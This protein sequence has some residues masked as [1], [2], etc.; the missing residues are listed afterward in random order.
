MVKSLSHISLAVYFALAFLAPCGP[1]GAAETPTTSRPSIDEA[2]RLL[3]EKRFREA[4]DMALAVLPEITGREGT[5]SPA[6]ADVMDVIDGASKEALMAVT[7]DLLAMAEHA[8]RIR[9]R[10]EEIDAAPLSKSLGILGVLLLNK[11]DFVAARSVFERLVAV[12]EKR[13]GPEAKETGW[14]INKLAQSIAR[15]GDYAAS[16]PHF[17]RALE[18]QE[19]VFGLEHPEVASTLNDFGLTTHYM[20]EYPA[21]RKLLERALAIREKVLGPEDPLTAVSAGNLAIVLKD[22]G[23]LAGAKQMYERALAIREKTLGPNHPWVAVGLVGLANVLSLA[24][25]YAEARPLYERGLAIQEKTLGAEHPDYA[26]ALENFSAFLRN[27]GDYSGA[28]RGYEQALAIL[29]KGFGPDKPQVATTL[30]SLAGVLR[31]LGDY[32]RAR[33]VN[34]RALRILE[35]TVGPDH[36]TTATALQNLASLEAATGNLAEARRLLER[37]LAIRDKAL[38]PEH[39]DVAETLDGLARLRLL[40]GDA[41]GARELLERSTAIK[42][43]ALGP[44]HP[45][46][47]RTLLQ[48][49]KVL[50][51]LGRSAEAEAQFERA[52]AI[53]NRA[54]PAE[55]PETAD[56]LSALGRLHSATGALD[57][58]GPLLERALAIRE[59]VL[60]VDHPSVADALNDLAVLRWRTGAA[61]GEVLDLALRAEGIAREQ[62]RKTAGGLSEAEA[63]RYEAIRATGLDAALTVL[64]AKNAPAEAPASVLD[65]LVRSRALVLD[66]IA[67][68]HRSIVRDADPETNALAASLEA[69]RNRLVR[70]VVAGPDPNH[71]GLYADRLRKAQAQRERAERALAGRST[72]FDRERATGS[73]GI[74]EVLAALPPGA[75]LV[76]YVVFD[77]LEDPLPATAATAARR[78]KS[79]SR[80]YLAFVRA[81]GGGATKVVPLGGAV[82]IDSLIEQW[83]REAGAR[84][85]LLTAGTREVEVLYRKIG[86]QLRKRVWDPVARHL[87][88]ARVVFVVPDGA[89]HLVSLATLPGADGRYLVET[90]RLVRY[91]SAERDLARTTPPAAGGRGLLALG[92]PDFDELSSGSSPEDVPSPS[93]QPV[94]RGATASCESFASL[95]FAPLQAA[96]QEVEEITELWIK[97]APSERERTLGL[98]GA[99]ADEAS[100][101]RLAPG[102]RILHLATHGFFA[103]DRCLSALSQRRRDPAAQALA[104]DNPL[105]LSGL[106]LAGANRRTQSGAVSGAGEDGILTADE[107][108]SIDLTSVEWA[109]LSACETGVGQVQAG[110]GVLGLRRAFQIAGA[111][112]LIMSLW[113]VEDESAREWMRGLY[114]NR[115]AGMSTAE[116]V[117]EASRGMIEARRR[118]GESTHPFYWGAFV[119]AGVEIRGIR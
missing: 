16:K 84:P 115:I 65:Q 9:E 81:P 56:A 90:G 34:E 117:R 46:V 111:A 114:R 38:G 37:A 55:H 58:A 62:F 61:G 89:L 28:R 119:A 77:R 7:P 43:K 75:A 49:G 52:L 82:A 107:I 99:E 44:E 45:F 69:A 36:P 103:Q 24:G 30:A 104:G 32:P 15:T 106:A 113:E 67:R 73:V 100:F 97:G 59:K 91:V 47:A 70:L 109:V 42:E 18:I 51:E 25:D 27:M 64:T 26:F 98:T 50:Q 83:R 78:K 92:G 48:Y 13:F 74:S 76:S 63:L 85:P 35:K 22:S 105:L 21:A 110:E 41:S 57:R 88:G 101:K 5:D 33:S 39:A 93:G 10:S 53:L 23:E 112:M 54:Y 87:R 2:R 60:G 8:V 1:I 80:E 6:A 118:A 86:E 71:P 94:A 66:E 20:G 19:K 96:R 40:A 17:E 12:D 14:A 72:V 102:R 79:P 68:R 4:I 11:N 3:E 31:D 116:A 29:E 108:A 95:R